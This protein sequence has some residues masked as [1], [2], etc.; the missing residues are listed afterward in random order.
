M[1][2]HDGMEFERQTCLDSAETPGDTNPDWLWLH[3]FLTDASYR[4]LMSFS[5]KIIESKIFFRNPP[6]ENGKEQRFQGLITLLKY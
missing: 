2:K 4:D 3:N 1:S 5:T 6:L